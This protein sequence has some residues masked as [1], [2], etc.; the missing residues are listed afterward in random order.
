VAQVCDGN[1]KSFFDCGSVGLRC[2]TTGNVPGDDGR[3]CLAPGCKREDVAAC[4][5]SCDGSNLTVCY[6][7]SPVTVDC[8][9]Y[10]FKKCSEYEFACADFES[11]DCTNSADIVSYATCE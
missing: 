3:H 5:E 2:E 7:G 4:T 8:Q 1:A 10:G 6:G 9:D 11:G